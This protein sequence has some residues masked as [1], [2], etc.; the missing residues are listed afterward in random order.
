MFDKLSHFPVVGALI[1]LSFLAMGGA[2]AG[3]PDDVGE[4]LHAP[5][6]ELLQK[7]V[8]DG[9]VDYN[10]WKNDEIALDGYLSRLSAVDPTTLNRDERFAFWINAYNAFTIKLI[11][12]HYPEIKSIKD[13]S[14]GKRWKWEGWNVNG[15]LV[16]LDAMEHKILRPMGDPRI[17]FAI[18]CASFSCPDLASEAYVA[19]RLDEQ[20]TAATRRFLANEE[21]GLALRSE[22]GMFG[23]MKSNLYLS[24]I[25]HWFSGD[26]ENK[27][28][29]RLEF[30]G[31][32]APPEIAS[33]IKA[34]EKSLK[35]KK[36]DY[37]WNLNGS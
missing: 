24:P 31:R 3:A 11:L 15:E 19:E 26:F 17:H 18:V 14:S 32:Y 9:I 13:I 21:K 5:F 28:M 23:G 16:S 4:S 29:T 30:V 36:L 8:A 6:D 37:D 1:I 25:F 34:D 35:I 33:K 20:L 7:H 27:E 2:W 12:N 10:G 22:K